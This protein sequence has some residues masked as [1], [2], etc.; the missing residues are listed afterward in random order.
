MRS[1]DRGNPPC[2]SLGNKFADGS[3]DPRPVIGKATWLFGATFP[4]GVTVGVRNLISCTRLAFL[5]VFALIV[6]GGL[7]RQR[8]ESWFVPPAVLAIGP[9]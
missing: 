1:N 4:H 8:P 5:L 6:Y 2:A 9:D 3:A 7:R